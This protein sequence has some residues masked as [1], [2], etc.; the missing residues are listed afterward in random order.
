M[1]KARHW[2]ARDAGEVVVDIWPG[3]DGDKEIHSPRSMCDNGGLLLT[4]REREMLDRAIAAA[5]SS[6]DMDGYIYEGDLCMGVNLL[7]TGN[8]GMH[9]P[10]WALSKGDRYVAG[11]FVDASPQI[12]RQRIIHEVRLPDRRAS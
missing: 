9:P 11:G 8:H 5:R 12:E 4:P 7:Q 1:T 3:R 10:R 6:K 2:T